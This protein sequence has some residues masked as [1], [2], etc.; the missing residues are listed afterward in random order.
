MKKIIIKQHVYERFN[1][2]FHFTKPKHELEGIFEKQRPT[3]NQLP[4]NDYS[5]IYF[6]IGSIPIIAVIYKSHKN[7]NFITI[8]VN[9]KKPKG[10]S[11]VK[12]IKKLKPKNETILEKMERNL[13]EGNKNA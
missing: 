7:I 3:I 11:Y 5:K 2:R 4:K 12:R 10:K 1:E 13:K 6:N 9:E 8:Y